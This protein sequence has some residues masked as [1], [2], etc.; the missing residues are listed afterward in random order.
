T[1][2]NWHWVLDAI[3]RLSEDEKKE[4]SWRYWSARA[5]AELGSVDEANRIYRVLAKERS[6]YG[7]LSAD[8]LSLDYRMNHSP[9]VVQPAEIERLYQEKP[10]QV[11]LEFLYFDMVRE[12]KSEWWHTVQKLPPEKIRAAA[13]LAQRWGWDQTAIFTIAIAKEWD[14]LELRFPLAYKDEITAQAKSVGMDPAVMYA[15]VRRESAFDPRAHSPAGARGL[16][17]IMPAT[18]RQVARKLNEKWR[19]PSALYLPD[20]SLRYGSHYFKGLLD[21]FDNNSAMAAAG[22]NAGPHRVVQW[23]PGEEAVDSDIWAETIPFTETRKYVAAVLEYA[24]IYRDKLGLKRIRVS[25]AAGR[26]TPSGR[27]RPS[28]GNASADGCSG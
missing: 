28:A 6:Y 5:L 3:G 22:Y 24:V 17:Q 18:G 13:K 21:S 19:G 15:L 25:E 23:L 8:R 12:A 14:D 7:F 20:V 9:T 26:V 2:G 4:S 1:T 27:I 16:M 10:F 11:M